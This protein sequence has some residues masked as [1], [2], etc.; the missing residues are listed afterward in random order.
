MI[1]RH[2][3]RVHALLSVLDEPTAEMRLV[4]ALLTEAG[5]FPTR[6]T[7]ERRLNALPHTLPAPMGCVGR[8][9]VAL[10]APWAT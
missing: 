3:H 10:I 1:V 2:L 8:C 9:V 4:R 6:R 7:W 5:R